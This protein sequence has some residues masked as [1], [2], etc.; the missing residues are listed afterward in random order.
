ML[1]IIEFS[2]IPADT[3]LVSCTT[4]PFNILTMKSLDTICFN[5]ACLAGFT[6]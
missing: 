4:I 2:R 1:Y 3:E 5:T 6:P